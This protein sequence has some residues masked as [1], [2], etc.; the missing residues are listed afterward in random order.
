[1]A[2][3]RVKSRTF[4]VGFEHAG[5]TYLVFPGNS[6]EIPDDALENPMVKS[7]LTVG[8]LQVVE[9][10]PIAEPEPV[11]IPDEPTKS[12]RKGK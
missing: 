9:P 1:M 4:G 5:E 11:P 6:L 2:T 7:H 8:T 12:R 3:V 10:E